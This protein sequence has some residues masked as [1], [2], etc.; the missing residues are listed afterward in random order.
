MIPVLFPADAT[1]F[2]TQGLGK[3]SDAIS[4]RVTEER[5]GPYE[6]EMEYPVEGIHWGDVAVSKI[7]IKEFDR[8]RVVAFDGG[9]AAGVNDS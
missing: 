4:C 2:T 5:N 8:G 1:V 9:Y 6:L 3:L 7:I